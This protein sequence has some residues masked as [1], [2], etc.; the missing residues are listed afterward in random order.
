MIDGIYFSKTMTSGKVIAKGEHKGLHYEVI[1]YGTHPCCYVDL[2]KEHKWY[3]VKYDAIPVKCHFGL[4]YAAF[5]SGHKWRIGWDYAHCDD[6]C[7]YYEDS[8]V[9][10]HTEELLKTG[11]LKKWAINELIDA[12]KNVCE[13]C[14]EV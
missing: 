12:C 5:S 4:T 1:S 14:S 9:F 11:Q 13:Q 3:G 6:Y 7:T 10:H 2:P 8:E